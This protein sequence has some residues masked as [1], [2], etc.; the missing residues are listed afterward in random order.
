MIFSEI[1]EQIIKILNEL[2]IWERITDLLGN[3]N[4]YKYFLLAYVILLIICFFMN[5]IVSH[6]NKIFTHILFVL[7]IALLV[8]NFCSIAGLCITNDTY[9]LYPNTIID[10]E[11]NKCKFNN[12]LYVVAIIVGLIVNAFIFILGV[13]RSKL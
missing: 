10:G 7:S 11:N 13:I 3:K 5:L 8:V 9:S 1:Y 2:N 6:D 12:K 4:L